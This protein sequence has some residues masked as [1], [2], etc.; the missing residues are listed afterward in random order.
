M[1]KDHD[2]NRL[3][4]PMRTVGMHQIAKSIIEHKNGILPDNEQWLYYSLFTSAIK[5]QLSSTV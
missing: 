5:F 2:T 3:L 1:N 4:Q